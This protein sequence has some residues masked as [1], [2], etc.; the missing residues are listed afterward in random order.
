MK[1]SRKI[2]INQPNKLYQKNYIALSKFKEK[3]GTQS[4]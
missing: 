2:Y 1:I 4:F 3:E